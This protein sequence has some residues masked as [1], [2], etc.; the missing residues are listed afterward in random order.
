MA[1]NRAGKLGD[2]PHLAGHTE[3]P[4]VDK[5]GV[6]DGV[7]TAVVVVVVVSNQKRNKSDMPRFIMIAVKINHAFSYLFFFPFH[8][9][10]LL[11]GRN[12]G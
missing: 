2:G 11:P 12:L 10:V 7:V 5:T 8:T 1:A 4:E 3:L 9:F 6:E